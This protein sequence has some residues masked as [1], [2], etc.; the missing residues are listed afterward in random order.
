MIESKAFLKS[1]RT[2]RHGMSS[3]SGHQIIYT[4]NFYPIYLPF[5]KPEYVFEIINSKTCLII[6]VR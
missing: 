5:M 6:K 1:K 4:A 2:K 3:V